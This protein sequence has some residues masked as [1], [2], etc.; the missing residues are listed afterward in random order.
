MKYFLKGLAVFILCLLRVYIAAALASYITTILFL[1]PD[2]L[3]HHYSYDIDIKRL[4]TSGLIGIVFGPL[5][6]APTVLCFCFVS[7]ILRR[8]K[9]KLN[10]A[11]STVIIVPISI[12]NGWNEYDPYSV[13]IFPVTAQIMIFFY[14]VLVWIKSFG[15]EK[16]KLFEKQYK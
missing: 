15:F 5:V 12:I 11:I 2:H 9:A 4:A 1:I 8:Y 7:F 13:F 10:I 6:A 3:G 16:M 14:V